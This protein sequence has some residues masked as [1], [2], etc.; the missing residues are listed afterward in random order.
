M[1]ALTSL[2]ILAG[3][4]YLMAAVG[5]TTTATT[6]LIISADRASNSVNPI[7]GL[8]TTIASINFREGVNTD[9]G[10][11]NT[12]E[13]NAPEG[14]EFYSVTQHGV[15]AVGRQLEQ[16]NATINATVVSVSSSKIIV[17]YSGAATNKI[18]EVT[19]GNIKIRAV[20]GASAPETV[21]I[22]ATG[23]LFSNPVNAVTINHVAGAATKLSFEQQPTATDI[24]TAISPAPTVLIQDQFGNTVTN[25]TNSVSLAIGNNPG[26]GVLTTG[27]ASRT[28]GVVT[29]NNYSIDASGTNY[30]LIASATGL[31]SATSSTFAVNSTAPELTSIDTGCFT[32]GTGEKTITLRGSNFARNATG[33]IGNSIRPTTFISTNELRMILLESDVAVAGN[34]SINVLNPSPTA[35]SSTSQN[36]VVHNIIENLIISGS[37]VSPMC[38]GSSR[39]YSGP[40]DY[41]D[42]EW[43]VT[44]GATMVSEN[45]TSNTFRI[46]YDDVAPASG[47]VTITV[48]A[49]NPCGVVSSQSFDILVNQTPPDIITYDTPI[50]FCEGGSVTLKALRLRQERRHTATS[51]YLM[52]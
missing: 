48:K 44:A 14:W 28:S 40:A 26:G 16:G 37:T 51:G 10:S 21:H 42:Y 49:K 31:E 2:M 20:T 8:F 33:R 19:I 6:P 34:K 7:G 38:T 11:S 45:A 35:S 43:S 9:F 3:S 18:E 24:Y 29:F 52:E 22:T 39:T 23:G 50:I 25:A 5:V 4:V 47:K 1:I 12:I 36:I 41:T 32:I 46:R 15:T 27:S 13:L 17:N 30:T